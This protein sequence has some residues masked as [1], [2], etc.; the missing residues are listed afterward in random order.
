MP[1]F[2]GPKNLSR[3]ARTLSN[4]NL[5]SGQRILTKGAA[6]GCV[7]QTDTQTDHVTPVATGRLFAARAY[8]IRPKKDILEQSWCTW[9]ITAESYRSCELGDVAQLGLLLIRHLWQRQTALCAN[10]I[11]VGAVA[12]QQCNQYNAIDTR[13]WWVCV[14]HLT[15]TTGLLPCTSLSVWFVCLQFRNNSSKYDLACSSNVL[16]TFCRRQEVVADN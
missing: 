11:T 9:V 5:T 7:Q 16:R 14:S 1:L 3:A 8:A 6:H 2:C 10:T 13:I 15:I 12:E 4:R